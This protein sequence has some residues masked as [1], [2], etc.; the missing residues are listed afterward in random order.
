MNNYLDKL[1]EEIIRLIK[2]YTPKDKDMKSSTSS[3]IKSL[4]YYYNYDYERVY[5]LIDEWEEQ[6][7][8]D[9]INPR[10][11]YDT[12]FF[13]KPYNNE[14]F[15]KYTLR[16]YKKEKEVDEEDK[17]LYTR[18]IP[19]NNNYDDSYTDTDSDSDNRHNIICT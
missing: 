6:H 15:Y 4:L 5:N 17:E 2:D 10:D 7:G 8:L 9:D 12:D 19:N 18:Y 13:Y 11:E 3:H 14:P 16:I 1:P